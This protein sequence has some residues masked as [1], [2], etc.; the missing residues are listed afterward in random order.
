M[1]LANLDR[2]LSTI[3]EG[4][5][6]CVCFEGAVAKIREAVEHLAGARML[7]ASTRS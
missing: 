6:E 1:T 3:A 2:L 4:L 5:D 7:L